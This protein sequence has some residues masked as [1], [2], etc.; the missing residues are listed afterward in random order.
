MT[1]PSPAFSSGYPLPQSTQ[2]DIQKWQ[3][4]FSLNPHSITNPKNDPLTHPLQKSQNLGLR[5]L[6]SL[7]L[8]TV[9]L[10]KSSPD[11][12]LFEQMLTP[13]EGAELKYSW[14][15][16]SCTW[17]ARWCWQVPAQGS[18]CPCP[19]EH[20]ATLHHSSSWFWSRAVA[21]DTER[22]RFGSLWS[23]WL[24]HVHMVQPSTYKP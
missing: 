12:T 23:L 20:A 6:K 13:E 19:A 4:D 18:C 24:N 21:Q 11:V 5:V 10:N 9:S 14:P 7:G 2:D 8:L 15:C 17:Q 16:C 3:V 1:W 22:H